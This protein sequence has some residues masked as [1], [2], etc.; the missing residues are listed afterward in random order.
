MVGMVFHSYKM[1]SQILINIGFIF[2]LVSS[3]Y[4]DEEDDHNHDCEI[5]NVF[6]GDFVSYCM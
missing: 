2:G 4:H 6:A 5:Y 3:I 1:L